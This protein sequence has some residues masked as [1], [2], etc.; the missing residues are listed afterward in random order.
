MCEIDFQIIAGLHLK[1]LIQENYNSQEEFADDFGID[2]RTVSRYVNDGIGK[3]RIIQ[4]LASFFG[5][6]FQDFFS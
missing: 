3:V 2:V 1:K 4:E 5:V 6:S